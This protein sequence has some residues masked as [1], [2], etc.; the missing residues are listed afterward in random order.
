[1]SDWR[2]DYDG[3]ATRIEFFNTVTSSEIF[4]RTVT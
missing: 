4:S 2:I 3:R 1:M